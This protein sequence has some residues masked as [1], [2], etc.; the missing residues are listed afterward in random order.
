MKATQRKDLVDCCI[1]VFNVTTGEEE[2]L[3]LEDGE[4]LTIQDIIDSYINGN[5]KQMISFINRFGRCNFV[6]CMREL[7]TSRDLKIKMY[8]YYLI[9]G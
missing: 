5:R 3:S 4:E 1:P 7:E 2:M 8:E 9:N 6:E